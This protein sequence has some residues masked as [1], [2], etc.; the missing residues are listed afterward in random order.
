MNE[1]KIELLKNK[2]ISIGFREIGTSE[3]F[4]LKTKNINYQFGVVFGFPKVFLSIDGN[5]CFS[6]TVDGTINYLEYTNPF[7]TL[8]RKNKIAKLLKI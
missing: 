8:I 1:Y 7:K 3:V 2:L 6:E 5:F 4:E